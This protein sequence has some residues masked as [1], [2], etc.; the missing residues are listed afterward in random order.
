MDIIEK[1]LESRREEIKQAVEALFKAN[2]KITDWDVPEADDE[3]GAKILISI[4]K[5][6]VSKIEEDIANGKYNNY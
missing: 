1:E 5:E 6:E 4:I 2:M 3:K